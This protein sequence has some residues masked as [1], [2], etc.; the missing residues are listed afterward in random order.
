MKG[1]KVARNVNWIEKKISSDYFQEINVEDFISTIIE[2]LPSTYS[3]VVDGHRFFRKFSTPQ[4]SGKIPFL[5]TITIF[6][7]HSW[8][9]RTC[10]M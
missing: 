5:M 1:T 8:L 3:Y 7:E 6:F 4:N 2:Y 9:Q 10:R